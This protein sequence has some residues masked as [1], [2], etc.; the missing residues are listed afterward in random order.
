MNGA[1][2]YVRVNISL[3]RD[4]LKE[5]KEKVP[6]RG[7]SR[8]LSDAAKEKIEESEK[9][10]AFKELLEAPPAFTFLKRKKGG[11]ELGKKIKKG[12]RKEIEKNLG[13]THLTC[14]AENSFR[15]R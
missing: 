9:E 6:S 7:I 14:E 11:S 1:S 4:L 3:P 2:N 12:R 10:K 8:F 15:Y 5:L 13:R